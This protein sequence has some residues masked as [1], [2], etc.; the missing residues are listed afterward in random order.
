MATSTRTPERLAVSR[1]GLEDHIVEARGP[2]RDAAAGPCGPDLLRLSDA[3]DEVVL[4]G[5]LDLNLSIYAEHETTGPSGAVSTVR[6][7][8]ASHDITVPAG[9]TWRYDVARLEALGGNAGASAWIRPARP[10]SEPT[11]V[12]ASDLPADYAVRSLVDL[13]QFFPSPCDPCEG[14]P[15]RVPPVECGPAVDVLPAR[16]GCLRPRYFN[17]MF[18]TREDLEAEQRYGRLK[19]RLQNRAFGTGVVWGLD[20][21][22]QGE[23]VVVGPGYGVDCCGND[24][25]ITCDYAVS[26]AS[27]LRDPAVCGSNRTCHALLLQYVE[28]PEEPRPVHGDGCQPATAG[29][30]M[31][32]IRETARL[33]LVPPMA[34]PQSPLGRF[35]QQVE[36]LRG[37]STGPVAVPVAGQAVVPAPDTV[38]VP[39]SVATTL[40]TQLELQPDRTTTMSGTIEPV[41]QPSGLISVRVLPESVGRGLS[42]MVRLDDG[43]LE[44]SIDAGGA[45]WTA[46][47]GGQTTRFT[48]A[49][50]WKAAAP[51]VLRGQTL[52]HLLLRPV[53]VIKGTVIDLGEDITYVNWP[54][55]HGLRPGDDVWVGEPPAGTIRTH[56]V[57][58]IDARTLTIATPADHQLELSETVFARRP[59]ALDVEI[60]P[61]RILMEPAA[62]TLPCCGP[63]CC[64]DHERL[65]LR[66]RL[67]GLLAAL[68]YGRLVQRNT[69]LTRQAGGTRVLTALRSYLEVPSQRLQEFE[70]AAAALYRA[71]C[72]ASLYPGPQ[73]CDPDGVVIGCARVQAGALCAV[74]PLDGRRWVVHQPL[75]DYWALQFGL[76]PLDRR[77]GDLFRRLC[78]VSQLPGFGTLVRAGIPS[79]GEQPSPA[80]SRYLLGAV[81]ATPVGVPP[82]GAGDVAT[83]ALTGLAGLIDLDLPTIGVL[84]DELF[85]GAAVT[86]RDVVREPER[87][88]AVVAEAFADLP[89][90]DQ[91]RQALR[92]VARD[93]ANTA[94]GMVP[95]A[96]VVGEGSPVVQVL[97][98][99]DVGSLGDVLAV[100]DDVVAELAVAVASPEQVDASIERVK[101]ATH[102]VAETVAASFKA[103]SEEGLTE[104][105][106]MDD[107]ALVRR[108]A[109]EIAERLEK[110]GLAVD[111]ARLAEAL[112]ARRS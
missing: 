50:D 55:D 103:L 42:G 67:L 20:V 106:S 68:L 35:L 82:L 97:E 61:T 62:P 74:D 95:V 102:R 34:T 54:A 86:S 96:G 16:G 44:A 91:P 111:S 65:R 105:K 73:T 31:S 53:D 107:D 75:L 84:V 33:R 30:E 94:L 10:R 108:L 23:H 57:E 87:A 3:A 7:P 18:I 38:P 110:E 60:P 81:A 19:R 4:Q 25:T 63:G 48:Y 13:G 90:R 59:G 36:E 71:W 69:L 39:F 70:V 45:V 22:L 89:A 88:R 5:P 101:A 93:V 80:L 47:Y 9:S 64:D 26:A 98:R 29:C 99:I 1:R 43:T 83:P 85:C 6:G 28:C 51:E 104:P 56:V 112:L 109:D 21:A 76:D 27:L 2:W 41:L 46:A 8:L 15:V 92:A 58:L 11:L 52:V 78:C 77:V 72:A 12:A 32:R 66:D 14:G 49:V 100:P 24:L 17:G 37:P 79:E 40:G